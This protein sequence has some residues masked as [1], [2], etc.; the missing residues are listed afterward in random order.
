[1][2][3]KTHIVLLN[4]ASFYKTFVSDYQLFAVAP[5]HLLPKRWI[6]FCTSTA[7]EETSKMRFA[8]RKRD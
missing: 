2:Y 3:I 6:I 5:I 7:Q 8:T 1:M 4:S